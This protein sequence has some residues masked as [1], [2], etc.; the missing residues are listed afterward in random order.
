[1]SKSKKRRSYGAAEKA[2]ILRRHLEDKVSVSDLC[3]EYGIQPSVFYGWQRQLFDRMEE[4]V[5]ATSGRRH[6]T[7]LEYFSTC[8]RVTAT[9]SV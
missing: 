7:R 9:A 3:E 6:Q 4:A 1:M 5:E 8:S 2:A